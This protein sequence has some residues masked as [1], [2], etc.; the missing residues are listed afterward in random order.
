MAS[1]LSNTDIGPYRDNSWVNWNAFSQL[2]MAV[3]RQNFSRG[4]KTTIDSRCS[5]KTLK[6]ASPR[7]RGAHIYEGSAERR[8]E[9]GGSLGIVI[10]LISR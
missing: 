5:K 9:L 6:R 10:S 7:V 3:V 1:A 8:Y 4:T 2:A